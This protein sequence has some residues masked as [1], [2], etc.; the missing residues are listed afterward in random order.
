MLEAN[1]SKAKQRV[2]ACCIVVALA[3]C[4]A[5][6]MGVIAGAPT[7]N[8]AYAASKIKTVKIVDTSNNNKKVTKKTINLAL[9][10]RNSASLKLECTP[11]KGAVKSIKWYSTS[12]K[13]ATVSSKGKVTAK[14]K[15]TA[16]I[17]AKVK[18]CKG[19][20]RTV[21]VKVKVSTGG[22]QKSGKVI[23]PST[24]S[25]HGTQLVKSLDGWKSRTVAA[26]LAA[27]KLDSKSKCKVCGKQGGGLAIATT[28]VS[29]A[30]GAQGSKNGVK[31][32]GKKAGSK[33]KHYRSKY[34]EAAAYIKAFDAV[35]LNK[36]K[37]FQ[38]PDCGYNVIVAVRY[39]GADNNFC[40]YKG[41]KSVKKIKKYLNS[42]AGKKKGWKKV[43][44]YKNGKPQGFSLQP[45]DVLIHVKGQES[46]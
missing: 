2:V 24:C 21:Y 3:L 41:S 13:V 43:G 35:G 16:T 45:G 34:K 27:H 29:L 33:S 32:E 44:T 39:S 12:K 5:L 1:M 46:G 37:T 15:G 17:K 30:T 20:S 14:K 7:T 19:K 42:S 6:T 10:G 9:T 28:A 25:K 11:V 31:I 40:N 22:W 8:T 26:P 23:T 36:M 4:S 18:A 38:Y